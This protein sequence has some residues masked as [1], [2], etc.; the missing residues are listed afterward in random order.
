M[1]NDE[2]SSLLQ[3]ERQEF[4]FLTVINLV[5]AFLPSFKPFNL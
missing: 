2:V 1:L 5:F 3:S 4:G